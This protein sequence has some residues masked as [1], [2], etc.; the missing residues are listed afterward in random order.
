M[1]V[2]EYCFSTL[3]CSEMSLHDIIDLAERH[4]ITAVELRA[5]S[6]TVDLISALTTQFEDPA[7]LAAFL[8]GRNI[9]IVALNTSIKLFES[10]DLS[11]IE[12]FIPWAEA[13]DVAHLR[14]FDGGK[15]LC[16]DQIKRAADLLGDWQARRRSSGL[17]VDLMIETHDALAHVEQL[18]AFV[19]LV[20]TA[21]I[22]WDTHHT[23]A[24]GTDLDSVWEGIAQ[25]IVHLH[26]KDSKVDRDGRRHY[27]LPGHG[28]FPMADLISL[29]QRNERHIPLSLEWERHW[30][31]ELPS[32]E[33]ALTTARNWWQQGVFDAYR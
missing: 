31:P 11:A 21:K 15:Q 17:N 25:N 1:S 4:D 27:V 13:A 8:A 18:V 22:L 29:L 33:D 12:Q 3:G 30:H 16:A 20:P 24:R 28:D 10:P 23:W 9:E 19:E 6:G 7:G 2:F 14:I 26:V 32:L 5:L